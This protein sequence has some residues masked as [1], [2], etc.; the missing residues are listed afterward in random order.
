[1]QNKNS[2]LTNGATTNR[3]QETTTPGEGMKISLYMDAV[4]R[5]EANNSLLSEDTKQFILNPRIF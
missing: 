3:C 4:L 5:P 1:M 2:Y